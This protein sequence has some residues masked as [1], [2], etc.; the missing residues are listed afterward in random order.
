LPF[1]GRQLIQTLQPP[2]VTLINFSSQSN[3]LVWAKRVEN[4]ILKK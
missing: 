4:G 2:K 1:S 3:P